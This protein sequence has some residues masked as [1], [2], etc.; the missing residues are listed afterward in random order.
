MKKYIL[1]ILVSWIL[2]SCNDSTHKN[3]QPENYNISSQDSIGATDTAVDKP[4]VVNDCKDGRLDSF[5]TAA[6]VIS[7]SPKI[8]RFYKVKAGFVY[9][10]DDAYIEFKTPDS[11]YYGYLIDKMI[12]VRLCDGSFVGPRSKPPA[13]IKRKNI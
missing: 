11:L 7:V 3:R 1:F 13:P 4:L 12:V 5:V 2:I 6:V 8:D 9:Q 10:G